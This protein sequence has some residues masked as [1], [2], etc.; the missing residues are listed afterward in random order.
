MSS[1][2]VFPHGVKPF[3]ERK[4]P[5]VLVM[6]DVDDTLTKPRQKGS[7]EMIMALQKLRD[8]TATAFVGG[9]DL[10]K[11]VWQLEVDGQERESQSFTPVGNGKGEA[12]GRRGNGH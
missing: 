11:I 3:A 7:S 12:S 4:L 9:S 6:F 10:S 2:D 1:A 8:Y 5:G